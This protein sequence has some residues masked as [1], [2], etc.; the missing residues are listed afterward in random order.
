MI[1][2]D[3]KDRAWVYYDTYGMVNGIGETLIHPLDSDAP[4]AALRVTFESVSDGWEWV[5][6]PSQFEGLPVELEVIGKI[7]KQTVK[8]AE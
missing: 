4:V 5:D 6:I 1:S 7:S 3:L 8:G 2:S